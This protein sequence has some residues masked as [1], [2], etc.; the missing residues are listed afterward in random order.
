MSL[1]GVSSYS[2]N[3]Y[4]YSNTYST[5]AT[6]FQGYNTTTTTSTSEKEGSSLGT[7]A[8]IGTGIAAVGTAIYS[9][10]KGKKINIAGLGET[11]VKNSDDFKGLKGIWKN[12]STGVKS[13]FTKAGREVS[14]TVKQNEAITELLGQL[15]EDSS[16]LDSN[17]LASVI[18]QQAKKANP[19]ATADDIK[20]VVNRYIKQNG[21][22]TVIITNNLENLLK[23]YQETN[24]KAIK[25]YFTTSAASNT[26]KNVAK[27]ADNTKTLAEKMENLNTDL[28]K[29]KAERKS[30]IEECQA[31]GMSISEIKND[32]K[33]TEL[34]EQ[35]NK[36][37]SQHSAATIERANNNTKANNTLEE[38]KAML[39]K[40]TDEN[41][42][43]R[44]QNN[45]EQFEKYLANA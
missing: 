43:A 24:T 34:N 30:Y 36:L 20:K 45:I 17:K 11:V 13:I 8:L 16:K 25:N 26:A 7:L 9:I 1:N 37:K 18:E 19:E 39:E 2:Y 44:I 15:G 41:E 29:V 32:S 42:K 4:A 10:K 40:T 28:E 21:D 6:N 38:M 27:N 3:P 23:G 5:N 12:L 33:F 31:K 14:S 35:Y 22:D